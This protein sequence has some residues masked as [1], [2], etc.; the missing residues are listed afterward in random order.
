MAIGICYSRPYQINYAADE[1]FDTLQT[2]FEP[3]SSI[4]QSLARFRI[5]FAYDLRLREPGEP[6][7]FQHLAFGVGLDVGFVN[8]KFENPQH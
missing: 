2:T 8:W 7:F 3:D 6:G 1:I 4:E 5:A